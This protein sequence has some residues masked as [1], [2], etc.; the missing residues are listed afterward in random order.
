MNTSDQGLSSPWQLYLGFA[1]THVGDLGEL[2]VVGPE[3]NSLQ[4]VGKTISDTG[5]VYE[6]SIQTPTGQVTRKVTTTQTIS[7]TPLHRGQTNESFATVHVGEAV[8]VHHYRPSNL[9]FWETWQTGGETYR[10]MEK[11]RW[12]V[13]SRATPKELP[14]AVDPA[15]QSY[16]MYA[17][18]EGGDREL[19][20]YTTQGNGEPVAF[21]VSMLPD[22]GQ[23]IIRDSV[24]NQ[25]I[26]DSASSWSIQ[27]GSTS[28]TLSKTGITMH[29]KNFKFD[30]MM[31]LATDGL[32]IVVPTTFD[33]HVTFKG[34]TS[35]DRT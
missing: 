32:H 30:D 25:Q 21:R 11:H 9:F 12:F 4:T 23:L 33:K 14:A 31:E 20:L 35:G 2:E 26:L 10:S 7:C 28:L 24:G 16:G 22:S 17:N 19:S 5:S 1:A 6:F 8:L 34:G 13:V 15:T 27:F 18:S 29:A 3:L